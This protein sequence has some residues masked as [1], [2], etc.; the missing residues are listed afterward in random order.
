MPRWEKCLNV[1]DDYMEVWCVP[2]ATM[3]HAYIKVGTQVS[4]SECYSFAYIP[5]QYTSFLTLKYMAYSDY[6]GLKTNITYGCS[7][8]FKAQNGDMYQKRMRFLLTAK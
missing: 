3:C 8:N 1:N 6:C 7:M 4:T 5:G 2:S